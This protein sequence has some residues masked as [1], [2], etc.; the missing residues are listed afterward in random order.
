MLWCES[1]K[2]AWALRSNAGCGPLFC[3]NLFACHV[4][5][6]W[7]FA[8]ACCPSATVDVRGALNV[9]GLSRAPWPPTQVELKKAFY[10]SAKKTHPDKGGSAARFMRTKRAFERLKGHAREEEEVL[11]LHRDLVEADEFFG[12]RVKVESHMGTVED[13]HTSALSKEKLYLVRYDDQEVEHLDRVQVAVA[14]AAAKVRKKVAVVTQ[15]PEVETKFRRLKDN[16][17]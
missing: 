13:I 10:K 5:S 15:K 14:A 7:S 1:W 6:I 2:Y 11:L 3:L 16:C 9:L 12:A 8:R 4:F 17:W